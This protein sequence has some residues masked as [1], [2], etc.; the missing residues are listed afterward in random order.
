MTARAFRPPETK[1]DQRLLVGALLKMQRH[2]IDT[3]DARALETVS[4]GLAALHEQLRNRRSGRG[5]NT[6]DSVT[7]SKIDEVY[8]LRRDQPSLSQQEIANRL[9]INI[10]R[11]SEILHGKRGA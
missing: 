3:K 11:V 9:N 2:G 7:P 5:R 6:A 8:R 1:R 10:G 4:D